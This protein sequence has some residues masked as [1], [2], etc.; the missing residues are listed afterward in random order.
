MPNVINNIT[1]VATVIS[2][3]AAGML[4]DNLQFIKSIDK[5]PESSFGQVNGY[6][7]G[8]T[9][10]ISK[11]ARF[12]V[13]NTVDITS[14]IQ[15]VT[16]EKTPLVLNGIAPIGVSLTSAEITTDLGLASWAKR[17]LKP[18][19][20]RIAQHVESTCL[21]AAKDAIYNSVGV[22]GST[23]FD[24]NTMLSAATILQN[25][26][27]P[28]SDD[29]FALL[30]PTAA[31][32]AVNAR[33]GLFQSSEEISKQYRNGAMGI[34]DGMTYLRNNLLPVQTNG[35]DIVFE[36]RT[37]VATQ[38]QATLVVEALTT[39]T[40]TVRK[41]TVFTVAGRN[42]VHP[43]TKVNSGILQ[44]FVVTAD[45]TADASGYATLSIS[46]AMYTTGTL[47]NIA[48][49]PVDGDA[50]TP[51]GGVS[52]SYAQQLVYCPSAFRFVSVPL[53]LPG[54]TDMSAQSTVNGITV[55][56]IRDYDVLKDVMIM[57]LD[58][59]YAFAVVR[60]EWAVR[61]TS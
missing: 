61:V 22:G 10:N 38:G 57:R 8:D 43:I 36:V 16:E 35:N 27:A 21:T 18:A 23:V 40:G 55:R 12:T 46:P 26:L 1:D 24:T 2:T 50:I 7:V 42:S 47:Q 48:S 31:Q 11:P 17:V 32:S 51:V 56:A 9:I 33:K 15:D 6:S 3:L 19:M 25:N 39:T 13:G 4:A 54:G 58:V 45:A 5:E 14:A 30:N 28:T 34:A 20:S 59:L 60:P 53:V 44:Q 29:M 41:G 52:T 49:F 37:T